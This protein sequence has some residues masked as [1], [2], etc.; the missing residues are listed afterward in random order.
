MA[1]AFVPAASFAS[2]TTFAGTA[3]PTCAKPSATAV[4]MSAKPMS[5][6]DA[7]LAG[8]AIL[9]GMPLAALAKSGTSPRISIFGVGSASSPFESG[10]QKGGTVLYSQYSD[11]E[12]AVF[13]RIVLESKD[14]IVSCNEPLKTKS[15][16][17]VR[18]RIRLEASDLRA[19]QVKVNDSLTDKDTKAAAIKAVNVFKLSLN[20]MDMACVEK[21]QS[22]AFKGYNAAIKDLSAWQDIVGF[23]S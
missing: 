6:R 20:K 10:F 21:N 2:R 13:K 5:R 18:A 17:D 9:T 8:A 16:Q 15:W 11:S 4:T 7:I 1:P 19:T 14:R 3:L 23:S 22:D 12:I